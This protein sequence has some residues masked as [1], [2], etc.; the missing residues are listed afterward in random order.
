VIP[1]AYLRVFRPLDAF[2]EGERV[3]WERYIVGGGERMRRPPVYRDEGFAADGRVGL[4]TA[5]R[6]DDADVRLVGGR[7]YVCPSRTRLRVLASILSLRETVPAEMAQVFVPDVEARRAAREL[8][9]L[10][11]RE[12]QAVP[13]MLQSPWHVPLR[14]F[15][16]VDD[17]E[18]HLVETASGQFRLYYWA[19]I[20]AARERATFALRTLRRREFTIVAE[21]VRDMVQW[22]SSF[23]PDCAVELDYAEVSLGFSWDELDDDHSARD[24][25]EAI[26]AVAQPDGL[27]RAM[28]L[29]QSVAG[30]WAEARSKESFN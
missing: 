16:L 28:D 24:L 11:R 23:H 5:D 4:L 27:D 6:P 2:P 18:R 14:W 30:R 8:A 3:E 29:Y 26:Q 22:L 17:A 19:P 1:C 12:P 10:K 25:W 13:S 21:S 7:Y 20:S 15:V 9:R